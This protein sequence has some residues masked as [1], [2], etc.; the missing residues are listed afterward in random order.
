MNNE[1]RKVVRSALSIIE[2]VDS[3][4]RKAAEL[5]HLDD[6]LPSEQLRA[7]DRRVAGWSARL[8]RA[9]SVLRQEIATEPH[10]RSRSFLIDAFRYLEEVL[11]A[12]EPALFNGLFY[13]RL[14]AIRRSCRLATA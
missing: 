1:R 5:S 14:D 4:I 11:A 6:P 3:D 7:R 8:S 13:A 2:E 10:T 9:K 12:P